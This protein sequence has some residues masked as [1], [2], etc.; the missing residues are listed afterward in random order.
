MPPVVLLTL[1]IVSWCPYK[2]T[3]TTW[4]SLQCDCK[5]LLHS[6]IMQTGFYSLPVFSPSK[7]DMKRFHQYYIERSLGADSKSTAE[8]EADLGWTLC[9]REWEPVPVGRLDSSGGTCR[10]LEGGERLRVEQHTKMR[11]RASLWIAPETQAVIGWM[12]SWRREK[13]LDENK[14]HELNI[15]AF[16]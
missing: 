10:G 11:K 1:L 14:Q 13:L 12:R 7:L 15:F 16:N 3:H 8:V 9:R 6:C 5:P 4:R 2:V